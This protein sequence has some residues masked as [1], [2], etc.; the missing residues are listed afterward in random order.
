MIRRRATCCLSNTTG[1]VRWIV[2][3]SDNPRIATDDG[4]VIAG[5]RQSGAMDSFDQYGSATGLMGNL[6]VQSWT[7]ELYQYGSV[8]QVA[9]IPV[10]LATSFWA[11][12]GANASENNAAAQPLPDS[13][14]PIYDVVGSDPLG[15]GAVLRSIDYAAYQGSSQIPLSKGVVIKEKLIYSYGQQPQPSSQTGVFQ[16]QV[17]T[18]GQGDFGLT[19]QFFLGVSGYRYYRVQIMPCTA[20]NTFGTP[21]WQSVINATSQTVLIN[22]DPGSTNGRTCR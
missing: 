2:P 17:G 14:K 4:G 18:R 7:G 22:Q 19:Q 9:G 1:N 10:P 13:V 20:T 21:T 8:E 3:N 6:P 11:V 5:D 12:A 15:A 16:D